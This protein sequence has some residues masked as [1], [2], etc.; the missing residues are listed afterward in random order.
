L[1]NYF[2]ATLALATLATALAAPANAQTETS[3]TNDPIAIQ[4]FSA[5]SDFP[6]SGQ[7]A[8]SGVDERPDSSEVTI[9]F[10]NT[11]KVPAT[12]VE[13]RIRA[14]RRTSI[15]VDKGTFAPGTRIVHTFDKSPLF[16]Q[17]SSVHVLAVTFADGSSWHR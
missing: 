15:I 16:D 6:P 11:A 5:Y 13:F 8:R 7:T 10:V 4:A 12:S 2:T 1:H 14:G 17:T 9:A 3:F